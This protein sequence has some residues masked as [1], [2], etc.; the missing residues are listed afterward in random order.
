MRGKR[1]RQK[2]SKKHEAARERP[3]RH[4]ENCGICAAPKRFKKKYLDL[5]HKKES[6]KE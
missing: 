3:K 5:I 2:L 1:N 4:G 6:L